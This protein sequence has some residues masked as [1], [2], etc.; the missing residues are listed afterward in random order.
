MTE[1]KLENPLFKLYSVMNQLVDKISDINFERAN[2]SNVK[3]RQWWFPDSP[4]KNDYNF[5]R[6]AIVFGTPVIEFYG[7]DS[8]IQEITNDDNEVIK[9]QYGEFWTVPV[10]FSVFVKK[11]QIHSVAYPDGT[12]HK[13]QNKK[14]ADHMIYVV[15]N[16]IRTNK[17][18]LIENDMDTVGKPLITPSYRDNDETFAADVTINIIVLSVWNKEYS[19]TDIIKSYNDT[20]TVTQTEE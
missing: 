1:I 14:Q 19:A 5:P 8:Y 11:G 6:G 7:N 13:L 16:A 10:T 20:Y 2:S 4:E 18:I 17:S 15:N 9:E 3:A 12:P